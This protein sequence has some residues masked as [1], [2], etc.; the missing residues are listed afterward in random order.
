[1]IFYTNWR[2]GGYSRF[3]FD[4]LDRLL[5]RRDKRPRLSQAVL[6]QLEFRDQNTIPFYDNKSVALLH[7][8]TPS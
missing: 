4:V 8:D 5:E 7:S 6:R 3:F 2:N 1:A